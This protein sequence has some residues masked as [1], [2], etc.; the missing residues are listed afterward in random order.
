MNRSEE[1]PQDLF[2][3]VLEVE[4]QW[5]T[6]LVTSG[7]ST[8]EEVAYVPIDEFRSIDGL[9]EQQIQDWRAR[10][11]RHLLVEAIGGGDEEDPLATA[12]VKPPK[13]TSGGSAAKMNDNEDR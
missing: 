12:T 3:R 5:A 7:F 8:L 2:V 6:I 9:D 4:P 1:T 11:R 13:P 10:A